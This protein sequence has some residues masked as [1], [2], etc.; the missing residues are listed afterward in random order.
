MQKNAWKT[1]FGQIILAAA[2]LSGGVGFLVG[3]AT[4]PSDT[5]S[6]TATEAD[7]SN[8]ASTSDDPPSAG[9]RE[10]RKQ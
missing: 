1:P 7:S 4:R 9:D 8:F 3:N 6:N 5:I 2:V 10:A